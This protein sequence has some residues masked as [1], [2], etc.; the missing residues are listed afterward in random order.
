MKPPFSQQIVEEVRNR[1]DIVEALSDYVS[2]KPSGENFKGLCPFHTEK[3]PSFVVSPAKQIFHCFGCGVGGNVFHFFMRYEG[4]SFPEAVAFLAQRAGIQLPQTSKGTKDRE[5]KGAEFY[6][7]NEAVA[8]YYHRLLCQTTEGE[9]GRAYLSERGINAK[10]IETFRLGYA[11]KQWDRLVTAFVGQK[12]VSPTLLQRG[13]LIK[14][15]TQGKGYYDLFRD[16]IIFPIMD[17]QGRIVAFGGRTVEEGQVPKYLNSPETPIYKKGA[18]LYGLHLA[19]QAIRR[20][21]FVIVVEGYFDLLAVWQAGFENVVAPLGTA[22]TRRQIQL[23]Q[24]Y[25]HE[26]VL[27]F[28]GDLA[29]VTAMERGYSL[30]IDAE[31]RVRVGLLPTGSDPDTMLRTQRREA[32][33]DLLDRALPFIEHLIRTR[34]KVWSSVEEKLHYINFLLPLIAKVS[35]SVERME[36]LSL[37]AEKTKVAEQALQRELSKLQ[38]KGSRVPREP[39][40]SPLTL[41]LTR[42]ERELIRLMLEDP[43]VIEKVKEEVSPEDFTEEALGEIACFLFALQEKGVQVT[44]SQL[45]DLLPHPELKERVT[46]LLLLSIPMENR[47]QLLQDYLSVMRG[48]RIKQQVEEIKRRVEA[49]EKRGDSVESARLLHQ[50]MILQRQLKGQKRGGEKRRP[51]GPESLTIG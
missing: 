6:Q 27:V 18:T 36:Y 1:N 44:P 2:L 11:P 8:E 22:L 38:P 4:L 14:P 23:L 3:T 9:R 50:F 41:S 37:L 29:G 28:D 17:R 25:T 49:A 7:L 19:K 45:I 40:Q 30:L 12:G 20:A 33:R 43:S 34:Q 35:N 48:K 21:G 47:N 24:A 42:G 26:I 15:R 31:M 46:Q 13:G 32:F 5:E 39:M 10:V 51:L 16:R